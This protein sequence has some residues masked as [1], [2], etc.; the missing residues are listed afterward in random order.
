MSVHAVWQTGVLRRNHVR[1]GLSSVTGDAEPQRTTG[2]AALSVDGAVAPAV[3]QGG[4]MKEGRQR[5]AVDQGNE[6]G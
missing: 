5:E 4:S 1:W 6:P 2:S 3:P